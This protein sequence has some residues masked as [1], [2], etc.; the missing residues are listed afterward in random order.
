MRSF[1]TKKKIL[2]ILGVIL[3]VIFIL[4]LA[5]YLYI[6]SIISK[7]NIVAPNMEEDP[8]SAENSGSVSAFADPGQEGDAS[9][10]NSYDEVPG[11]NTAQPGEGSGD[12]TTDAEEAINP[13]DPLDPQIAALEEKIR[14]NMEENQIPV[15]SDNNVF[16]VLLIGSDSRESGGSGRSDA[17]ILVSVNKKTKKI[18][19]TS[20][21]RDIYVGI[22]GKEENNRIN[23]AYAYGRSKLLLQTVEQNFKIHVEEYASIDFFAFIDMVDA[24]GGITLDV[25]EAEIPVINDYISEINKLTGQAKT[26]DHLKEPGT[27]LL[28]GKQTLGYVRNRYVGNSD[29][30]R[31]ARQRRVLEQVFEK[32]KK[33]NLLELQNLMNLILPQ[34]TTNLTEKEIFSLILSLPSYMNYDID[35]WSIPKSGTYESVRIRGMA[36]LGIDFGANINALRERVYGK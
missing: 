34:I 14:K 29:F 7:I 31:T 22:P 30:E 26:K 32:V 19:V 12:G 28:S 35:Q 17:M 21:L 23:T 27:L 36:V 25:T 18:I 24:V 2:I 11:F 10:G 15:L 1:F 33:L 13:I 4:V 16:N 3:S 9:R 8:G 5:A 6:H 20:I